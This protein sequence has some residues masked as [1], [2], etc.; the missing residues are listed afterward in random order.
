MLS[1][2]DRGVLDV[3]GRFY[4]T[5]GAREEAVRVELGLTYTR[6][7]ILLNRLLDDPDAWA[8]APGTV[9]RWRRARRQG[10]EAREARARRRV[11]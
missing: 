3:A 5:Q 11:G 2:R 9:Q 10:T 8:Y 4:R 6:Y 1:D 7:A